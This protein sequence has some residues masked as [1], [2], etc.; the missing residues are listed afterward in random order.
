MSGPTPKWIKAVAKQIIK[1]IPLQDPDHI[2][3]THIAAI[4]TQAHLN[5]LTSH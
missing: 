4:I 1:E 5:E 3:E 2:L